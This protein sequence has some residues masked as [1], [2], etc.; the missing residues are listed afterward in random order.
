MSIDAEKGPRIR[1][2][3]RWDEGRR[4]K[5]G[6]L[7]AAVAAALVAFGAPAAHARPMPVAPARVDVVVVPA[8]ERGAA[9][10]RL[11]RRLGGK[12]GRRLAIVDGFTA[13]LP[14]G[15]VARLERSRAVRAVSRDSRMRV[16]SS[17][18]SDSGP[19]SGY[20]LASAWER[21]IRIALGIDAPETSPYQGGGVDVAVLDS[22]VVPVGNLAA[23]GRVVI[24][25]DFS[26]EWRDR[27]LAGLDTFGH[28]T[29]VA[30]I[31]AGRDPLN[32]IEGVAPDA[33]IVS[34]KVAGADGA[35]SLGQVL[36]AL[37]WIHRNRAQRGLNI[38]VLNVSLGVIEP[39]GYRRAPL[40]WAAER[41]WQD[42]I[43]VVAAAGN[44][45]AGAGSLDLPA[46]D[47]F[48]IAVGATDSSGTDDPADDRVAE[49]SSRSESRPPDL[50]APGTGVVSLRVPGST[51][52][53]EFPGARVGTGY[54]RGSGTSQAA[55]VVSGL[56]A[57]LI[58][59]RP[60]LTPDQLK[61]VLRAGAVDLPDPVSAD[62][63]GRIDAVRSAE[64]PTPSAGDARQAW[65]PAVLDMRK[66][67]G[68]A[69]ARVRGPHG[70]VDDEDE[71]GHGGDD[72]EAGNTVWAGR[73]W[74]GRRWSGMKWSGRR[75]SGMKWSGMKWSGTEWADGAA[76]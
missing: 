39:E 37:D 41:L 7:V 76:G 26:L 58:G 62:G 33:R 8:P 43:A 51:L 47:P 74:S 61:F 75:W 57:R 69:D 31:I 44:N 64:V 34:V 67:R 50:V 72:V 1:Y 28:G 10:Q 53:R 27:D 45:G 30:G 66:L 3:I 6:L 36:L 65:E 55:A 21:R 60:E 68:L 23:P 15:A 9:A 24:G 13:S 49:F 35:T 59:Q 48:V 38:R 70:R 32:G 71:T 16:S 14:R 20:D 11:T 19:G 12:V 63:A 40:A 18:G 73:R 56:A 52:D 5:R 54:F 46:A 29:H 42:G 17:S 2:G 25:P 22:G 4:P